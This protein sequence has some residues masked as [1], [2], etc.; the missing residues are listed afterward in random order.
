MSTRAIVLAQDL[1]LT[2]SIS[3]WPVMADR[4]P[5]NPG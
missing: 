4:Q 5:G 2:P 3:F 1:I